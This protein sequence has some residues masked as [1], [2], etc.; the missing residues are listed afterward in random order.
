MASVDYSLAAKAYTSCCD[1]AETVADPLDR[2]MLD[3][4]F[5]IAHLKTNN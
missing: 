3:F 2:I 5:A 1:V 4:T